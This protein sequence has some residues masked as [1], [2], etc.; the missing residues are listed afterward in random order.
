MSANQQD[1]AS[2]QHSTPT[3]TMIAAGAALLILLTSTV[4]WILFGAVAPR[5]DIDAA[6]A[7]PA[8]GLTDPGLVEFR[9]GERGGPAVISGDDPDPGLVE[10]RRGE[11]G[12]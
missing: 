4:S 5:L 6:V 12:R 10:H 1:A 3:W 7:A 2:I 8:S 9:R 11:R